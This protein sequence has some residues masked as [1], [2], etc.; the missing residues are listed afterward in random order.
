MEILK[1]SD[2]KTG[3]ERW[4]A[5]YKGLHETDNLSS[6]LDPMGKQEKWFLRVV[7]QP[8]R[9]LWQGQGNTTRRT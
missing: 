8:P 3:L 4:P 5:E 2:Q 1:S 7:F 6:A 9:A